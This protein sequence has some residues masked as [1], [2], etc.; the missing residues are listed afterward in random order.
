MTAL[1]WEHRY[2]VDLWI[3][4]VERAEVVG[5]VTFDD[6]LERPLSEVN[7]SEDLFLPAL[8]IALTRR[9]VLV[10]R[11]AGLYVYALRERR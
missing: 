1:G 9:F 5:L 3:Q 4:D 6:L 2:P 11:A 10:E 8:R 7:V